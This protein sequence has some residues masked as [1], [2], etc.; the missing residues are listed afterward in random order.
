MRHRA[1]YATGRFEQ[2]LLMA[3]RIGPVEDD[4]LTDE[5]LRVGW[6]SRGAQVMED[7][8]GPH[9]T[10]PWGWWVFEAGEYPPE[11]DEDDDVTDHRELEAVR[12][13]ELGELT[14]H[15]LAALREQANEAR[16]RVGTDSERIWGGWREHGV[17]M[18][19]R[20]VEL[21]EAVE[22]AGGRAA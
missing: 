8:R 3:L 17:S 9:G 14:S 13:A 20:A 15:E 19:V 11:P 10:R 22:R 1:L 12:L 21:W 5:D 6:E 2:D 18:D 7:G 16:L 4:G